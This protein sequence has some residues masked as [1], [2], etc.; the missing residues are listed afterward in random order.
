MTLTPYGGKGEIKVIGTCDFVM[1]TSKSYSM[2]PFHVVE[3]DGGSLLGYPTADQLKILTVVNKIDSV[4]VDGN[5]E[6]NFK[7]LFHGIG[8]HK[9]R[10]VKLHIDESIHP[11]TQKPRRTPFHLRSKVA[12]EIQYL[13]DTDIIEKVQG[14][15]TPW[16]SPIV[17]PPKKDGGGNKTL[18][19]HE[20][21]K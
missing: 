14:E 18:R 16:I 10:Q 15:P 11:V 20:G 2:I 5:V 21:G 13:V 8:K 4:C 17:T 1:E 6:D 3:G 12:K 19:R 9:G 7:E